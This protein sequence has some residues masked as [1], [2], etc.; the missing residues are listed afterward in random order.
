MDAGGFIFRAPGEIV[1]GPGASQRLGSTA[2]RFGSRVTVV[3]DSVVASLPGFAAAHE[4]L[5]S[6]GLATDI[7][8]AASP[9]VPAE[10]VDEL[11]DRVSSFA[12]DALVGFGGGSCMDLAKAL[13][14][15]S[16]HGGPLSSFYGEDRIPGPNV[17]MIA[18]PTTSGTG[19]EVSPVA[20]V[21]D[22]A[23]PMKIGIASRYLIPDVALVDPLL[24]VGC[25]RSV[26]IHS[27]LDALTHAIESF[28]ARRIGDQGVVAS[29]TLFNGS[30][31]M[32][33]ALAPRSVELIF[34]YLRR[35]ANEPG[36][37]EARS[38]MAQASLLAGMSFAGA[39]TALAHALQY[40]LGS[41]VSASHGLGVAVLLPSVMSFNS[42]AAAERFDVLVERLGLPKD[43]V[44]PAG[45]LIAA[46]RRLLEDLGVPEGLAGLGVEA[47][48]LEG[49]AAEAASIDRLVSNNPRG[50]DPADLEA[51]LRAA[52]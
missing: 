44:D 22:P 29:T 4:S 16:R 21:S 13:A 3:T 48:Q 2:T 12:P 18:V 31:D 33:A 1:F 8:S 38:A 17:P 7:I 24:T 47:A 23:R 37:L 19:S 6:A 36:D 26:T 32:T 15:T 27:G 49:I 43:A 35:A 41:R 10:L 34:K 51:I 14:T 52:L 9:E 42:Q 25:P 40:P 28:T 11:T 5:K 50:A 45:P 20:V 30:S 39:G 46:F